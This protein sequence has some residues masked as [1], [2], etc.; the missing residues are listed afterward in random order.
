MR[1]R[2]K[3]GM[4]GQGFQLGQIQR[5]GLLRCDASLAMVRC[6]V[7][8]MI[9]QV[10]FTR[11]T[12]RNQG[13]RT[14]YLENSHVMSLGEDEDKQ[15]NPEHIPAAT[16]RRRM[17]ICVFRIRMCYFLCA[18]FIYQFATHEAPE[19]AHILKVVHSMEWAMC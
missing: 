1:S 15:V 5:D 11:D 12:S 17:G 18:S 9:L 7:S 19:A 2:Q 3:P 13:R 10:S 4:A 8:P 6:L 14:G 16:R